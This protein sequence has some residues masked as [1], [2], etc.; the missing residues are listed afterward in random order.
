MQC[1]FVMK[2]CDS[3]LYTILNLQWKK[4]STVGNLVLITHMP[5]PLMCNLPNWSSELVHPADVFFLFLLTLATHLPWWYHGCQGN[6]G[7]EANVLL[8]SSPVFLPQQTE[9]FCA[10]ACLLKAEWLLAE[11]MLPFLIYSQNC[12]G[13]ESLWLGGDDTSKD[14][15]ILT[16]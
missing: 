16:K 1:L 6:S 15:L 7:A 11:E 13:P 12:G 8:P 10:T 2:R 5:S 9:S 14:H 4:K 3:C